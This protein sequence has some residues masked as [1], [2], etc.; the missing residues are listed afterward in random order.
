MNY[1]FLGDIFDISWRTKSGAMTAPVRLHTDAMSANT[2]IG[3]RPGE[4]WSGSGP[5]PHADEFWKKEHTYRIEWR[6]G[7]GGFIR[8]SLDKQ[9]SAKY[10]QR[11]YICNTTVVWL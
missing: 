6:S 9:V 11:I 3:L 7:A 10:S 4:Q 8:W 5:P 2:N 1:N